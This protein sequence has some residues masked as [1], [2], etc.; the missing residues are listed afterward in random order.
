[1]SGARGERSSE[2]VSTPSGRFDFWVATL[3]AVTTAVAF[4]M[5]ILTLPKS[6]PFCIENCVGVILLFVVFSI[7]YG[8]DVEYRFEVAA[9]GVD[10]TVVIVIGTL[11]A[12]A[13]RQEANGPQR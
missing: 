11:L 6:G 9:I 5:A 10:W 8:L 13:Y 3:N 7:A 12:F 4:V 2:V 1:M